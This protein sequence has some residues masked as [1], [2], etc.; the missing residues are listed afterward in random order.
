M[1]TRFRFLVIGMGALLVLAVFTFP[2]WRSFFTPITVEEAFPGLPADQQSAFKKLPADQQSALLK[3]EADKPDEALQMARALIAGDQLVPTEQQ[4]LPGDAANPL[5]LG[6][7][8]FIKIDVLHGAEGKATIYQLSDNSRI[9]RLENFRATNGPELHIYLAADPDPR[10]KE[11]VGAE[12]TGFR[13]LGR[14]KGTVGS[15]N[16][17]IPGDIDLTK[18]QSVVLYC[19]PLAVVF[20]TATLG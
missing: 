8:T 17:N 1:N 16:Y 10:T 9:L 3:L 4:A 14:L 12:G 5:V 6:S 13:D 18:F 15:Q 2:L 19:V 20:S 11:A 7:G